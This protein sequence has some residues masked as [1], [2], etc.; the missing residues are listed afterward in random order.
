MLARPSSEEELEVQ[1]SEKQPAEPP[2]SISRASIK[3]RRLRPSRFLGYLLFLQR[4]GRLSEDQERYLLKLQANSK[5][6]TLEA[7]IQLLGKLIQSPRSISRSER[8][9]Q[10]VLRRCPR[11][12]AKSIVKEKRR[13]GV[14]YR[15]KG[16]LRPSHRPV[17][18]PPRMWWSEDL[19]PAF[20]P[21]LEEPRWI[22]AEELY[23]HERLEILVMTWSSIRNQLVL[24]LPNAPLE[25]DESPS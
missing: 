16:S 24:P 20:D 8:D 13:I 3:E 15:D 25:E 4:E 10:E 6:S 1:D 19:A 5:F 2:R 17:S 23:G 9:L 12:A 7:A 14:G 11:I 22:T 18:E 21:E